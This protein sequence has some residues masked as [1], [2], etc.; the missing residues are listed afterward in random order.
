MELEA[1]APRGELRGSRIGSGKLRGMRLRGLG[2]GGGCSSECDQDSEHP[3]HHGPTSF[4]LG[5]GASPGEGYCVGR[6]GKP[7]GERMAASTSGFLQADHG[8]NPEAHLRTTA[9][10]TQSFYIVLGR[11]LDDI[12][13]FSRT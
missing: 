5:E 6:A 4:L 2:E 9:L 1:W 7:I 12:A 10:G 8:R 13:A 11:I 3:N